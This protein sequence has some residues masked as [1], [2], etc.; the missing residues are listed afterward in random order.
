MRR[1]N[2]T[3]GAFG[4]LP[5]VPSNK[6]CVPVQRKHPCG[7]S[8]KRTPLGRFRRLVRDE[9]ESVEAVASR[10]WGA[11]V[12]KRVLDACTR[13]VNLDVS[14]RRPV[15]FAAQPVR[16]TSARSVRRMVD[17]ALVICERMLPDR[18]DTMRG[19]AHSRGLYLGHAWRT[20]KGVPRRKGQWG[21]SA[22]V[23]VSPRQLDRYLE[24]LRAA[25]LV[26]RHQ[27]PKDEAPNVLR[28]RI[29]GHAYAVFRLLC[30][31]P[32]ELKVLLGGRWVKGSRA[33]KPERAH[34]LPPA[35]AAEVR[36]RSVRA[37][38]R[39]VSE[40]GRSLAEHLLRSSPYAA[41][42]TG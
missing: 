25:G 10:V 20:P 31:V 16:D 7:S 6:C 30:D 39:T 1:K 26:T 33:P 14:S 41:P 15:A 29:S 24:V 42:D 21:V 35:L 18:G 34:E 40:R 19:V 22:K 17:L 2:E 38:E 36:E 23:G 8:G 4:P 13:A 12:G 11:S 28:G 32:R 3:E 9:S 37:N 27:P 5:S